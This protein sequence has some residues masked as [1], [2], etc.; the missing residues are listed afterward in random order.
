MANESSRHA[1]YAPTRAL[2]VPIV[3]IVISA[4]TLLIGLLL[5]VSGTYLAIFGHSLYAGT[6]LVMQVPVPLCLFLVLGPVLALVLCTTQ[7]TRAEQMYGSSLLLGFRIK[8]LNALALWCAALA[9]ATLPLIAIISAV[10]N[11]LY[12]R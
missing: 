10:V 5:V 2:L 4:P 8:R 3:S 11:S 12:P 6:P 9:L 1:P 7:R